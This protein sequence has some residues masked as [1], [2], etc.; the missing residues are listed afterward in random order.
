[1]SKIVLLVL[2]AMQSASVAA[3]PR[4]M[5]L[6][7]TYGTANSFVTISGADM[8]TSTRMYCRCVSLIVSTVNL[9]PARYFFGN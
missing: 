9:I 4:E 5:E 8:M 2:L 3:A 6:Y 1:M 7:P